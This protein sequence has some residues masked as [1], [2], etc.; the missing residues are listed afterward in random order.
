[1]KLLHVDAGIL[2]SYSASRQLTAEVVAQ[3]LKGH[4]DTTVEYLDVAANPISHFGADAIAV[5]GIAQPE[6]NAAQRAE[7][8]LSEQLVSQF[9]AADVIVIGAPFYNF[10]IPTQ[11]KAWIDRLAQPGRT[12]K[13]VETGPVG[14]ATGKTVIV[15]STR[16]GAY[17]TSE[18]G[19]AM[20]HQESYLKVVFGFFGV[21]DVRIVRAE[22]LAMGDAPKAAAMSAA[23]AEM[24]AATV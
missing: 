4:P 7:N 23:R 24:A 9:L 12:F 17:A 2:G 3:W 18:G 11:L 13:Y 1:M 20:E 5:K 14:L 16:G 21:T 15:A 22:G 10:S 19:Q 8:A 6:P